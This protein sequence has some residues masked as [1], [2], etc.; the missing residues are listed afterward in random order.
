MEKSIFFM[1]EIC[2]KLKTGFGSRSL[3]AIDRSLRLRAAFFS[4]IY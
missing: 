4:K 1:G 3:M 2:S